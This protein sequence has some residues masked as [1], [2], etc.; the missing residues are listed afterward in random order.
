LSIAQ[1]FEDTLRYQVDDRSL[2]SA[3]LGG[4]IDALAGNVEKL[5]KIAS[6]GEGAIA[7]Q[8]KLTHT[9]LSEI[10]RVIFI[11]HDTVMVL[12]T[13][14][15]ATTRVMTM[16]SDTTVTGG[17]VTALFPV[18][19]FSGRHIKKKE[20]TERKERGNSEIHIR[21]NLKESFRESP[22]YSVT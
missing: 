11:H 3:I 22:A 7:Q 19:V 14:V 8:V 5:I 20:S 12:S 17:D 1:K 15:T 16:T 6:R 10:T 2:S 21:S 4:L 13:S 18:L 9:D